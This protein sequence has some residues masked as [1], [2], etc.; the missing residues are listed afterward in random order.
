M[1]A[2]PSIASPT[3]SKPSLTPARV[4]LL[5]RKCACGG[6]PG[7]SGE[8]EACRKKTLQ[9]RPA[10]PQAPSFI[11]RP[12]FSVSEVPPIVHEVL[13]SPGQ[14][15]DAAS[16]AFMEPRFGHDFSQVRAR[17]GPTAESASHLGGEPFVPS[18]S[19]KA[20]VGGAE[21]LNRFGETDT[22]PIHSRLIEQFREREQLP[23][24]GRDP[25][26]A[27]VGPSVAQIKYGGLLLPCPQS[28]EVAAVID[29]R[30][31]ALS[32]GFGTAYGIHAQMR[33]RPD[34]KTWDGTHLVESLTTGAN[35][36]PET[37]TRGE[38]CSG[39]ST[40]IVGP[41]SGGSTL[42]SGPRPGRINRFWDFHVTHV[43]PRGVSVMHDATRNPANLDT[44]SIVCNQEYRCE[45][46]VIGRHAIT[47]TYSKG[48]YNGRNVTFVD[49]TK[50]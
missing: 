38:P 34:A 25:A 14:P 19:E 4:G 1:F 15:L 22:D 32:A 10:N 13:R 20:V 11:N 44:C 17:F 9:R 37:L 28:T 26:G 48:T 33:V 42:L 35:S 46:N 30:N 29:M 24:E 39:G 47:R 43:R 18:I 31:E 3:R 5:Q 7:P 2:R 6:T 16:R 21:A 23:P 12:A 40:F 50:T 27:P 8:C 45:G 49:V 41:A 36:C